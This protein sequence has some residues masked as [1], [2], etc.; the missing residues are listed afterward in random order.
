MQ[1]FAT[2]FIAVVVLVLLGTVFVRE[3]D[4]PDPADT[5]SSEAP[6]PRAPT[7]VCVEKLDANGNATESYMVARFV[8]AHGDVRMIDAHP[9][10]DPIEITGPMGVTDVTV[11]HADPGSVNV[12]FGAP[13]PETPPAP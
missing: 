6:T 13:V 10:L 11:V 9:D 7:P 8:A 12:T 4:R 3:A 2:A 5:V 1:R